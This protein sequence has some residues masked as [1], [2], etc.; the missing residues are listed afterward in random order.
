MK[1]IMPIARLA[2]S[3]VTQVLGEPTSGSITSASTT[4]SSTGSM[5]RFGF[6][7]APVVA[8]SVTGASP[9]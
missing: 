8:V 5:S 4:G 7:R 9:G 6:G 3:S 2:A 1:I